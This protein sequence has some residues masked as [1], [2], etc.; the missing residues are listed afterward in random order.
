M[1][2]R[3]DGVHHQEG[4]GSLQGNREAAVGAARMK[5]A[6][7]EDSRPQ[8]DH[9]SAGGSIGGFWPSGELSQATPRPQATQSRVEGSG[10]TAAL[11][12]IPRTTVTAVSFLSFPFGQSTP[13]SEARQLTAHERG[14]GARDSLMGL[15]DHGCPSRVWGQLL[16]AIPRHLWRL[17]GQKTSH[18]PCC[19]QG[20]R[21]QEL[22]VL[23]SPC[24]D[25][26]RL[27]LEFSSPL[28]AQGQGP[29]APC[30]ALWHHEL[31]GAKPGMLRHEAGQPLPCSHSTSAGKERAEGAFFLVFP[32]SK[33]PR[34]VSG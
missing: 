31:H 10:P 25:I 22:S 4:E 13:C 29:T 23:F 17:P 11:C 14:S 7:L 21:G 8:Q 32:F 27:C 12:P 9:G 6:N 15:S 19:F 26:L 2:H 3:W 16:P 24:R 5:D 28:G 1:G 33:H 20:E 18:C 30:A 34:T